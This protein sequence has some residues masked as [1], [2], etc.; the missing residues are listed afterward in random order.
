MPLH[1]N[2]SLQQKAMAF[3][4]EDAFVKA[5]HSL[6]LEQVAVFTQVSSTKDI[7]LR[8]EFIFKGKGIRPKIDAAN[9]TNQWSP[10]GSYRSEHMLKTIKNLP[11]RIN[12]FTQKGFAIIF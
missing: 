3:K 8:P 7:S 9:V 1:R 12:P 10:S 2:Q 6:S 5:N 4:N 11:N